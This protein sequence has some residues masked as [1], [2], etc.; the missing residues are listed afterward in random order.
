MKIKSNALPKEF[1]SPFYIMNKTFCR[2]FEHYIFTKK[3]LVKGVYNAYSYIVYGKIETNRHWDVTYK[4][5][6]YTGTG[7]L[8]FKRK[9]ETLLTL[10]KWICDDFKTP[11][12]RIFIRKKRPFDRLRV[13]YSNMKQHPKYVMKL[14]GKSSALLNEMLHI[15]QPLFDSKELYRVQLKQNKL[16]IELRSEE[17]HFDILDKLLEM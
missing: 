9:S 13:S 6:V 5:A 15:F 17:Q 1:D 3:G 10:G 4:K 7:N 16:T 8:L 2:D 14:E 12:K 11:H